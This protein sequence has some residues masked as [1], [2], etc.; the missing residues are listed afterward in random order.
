MSASRAQ[1]RS[2]SWN[3]VR[4]VVHLVSREAKYAE[5]DP[6]AD[7]ACRELLSTE[8]GAAAGVL[9]ICVGYGSE[10]GTCAMLAVMHV[11]ICLLLP[12]PMSPAN[13]GALVVLVAADTWKVAVT[14]RH[15]KQLMK[16]SESE[17]VLVALRKWHSR[18]VVAIAPCA[19]CLFGPCFVTAVVVGN[20]V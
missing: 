14:L 20:G 9:G 18:M 12:V 4:S 3:L 10:V 17:A 7:A 15:N 2:R 8:H 1:C 13:A 11:A 5:G 6:V 16:D 19:F